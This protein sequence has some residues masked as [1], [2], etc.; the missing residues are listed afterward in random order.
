MMC[1]DRQ[2]LSVYLDGE[3]PSP[4]KEKLETHLAACP[5]C[6]EKLGTY[7]LISRRM[8]ARGVAAQRELV[9]GEAEAALSAVD[10][11][12]GE[13]RE[14]VWLNI[15]SST[16]TGKRII[17]FP[18]AGVSGIWRRKISIPFP[19]AAAMAAAVAAAFVVVLASAWLRPAAAPLPQNT[20][21]AAGIDL[22]GM[23][24][25]S[26]MNGV[27]Q[28]L[29][30]TDAGDFVILRLP[31]S[32]NFRSSGEPTILKAA[33]YRPQDQTGSGRRSPR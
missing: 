9:T 15:T 20:A 1:P 14:R 5:A 32:R 13:A 6:R 31:E 12:A 8:E 27:L 24:P 30:D 2:I 28:Y 3:L 19:A 22:Q 26:D 4:W 7:R 25:V 29:G 33:D 11:A 16:N 10:Q 23:I 18:G 17:P 21:V